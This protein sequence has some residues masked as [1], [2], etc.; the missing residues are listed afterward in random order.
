MNEGGQTVPPEFSR[1][2]RC[3]EIGRLEPALHVE[4]NREE[5]AALAQRFA[6]ASIERL[7]A[8]YGLA[9]EGEAV[10]AS[11]SIKA[12]LSQPCTATGEPVAEVIDTP[13]IIRFLPE[14]AATLAP[15]DEVELDAQECDTVF[16]T[17]GRIDIGEAVAET[18]ALAVNPF[19]R[20][21]DA[22]AFLRK[23]GVISEEEAIAQAS[24]FAALKSI[25]SPSPHADE[26]K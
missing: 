2:I 20:S 13:F 8:N 1:V 12:S 5:C 25:S 4:A 7:S 18:L 21:P 22:D 19:P 14:D 9:I 6:F 11:G 15:G 3:D 16:Y 10:I 24:P 23:M 17:D 26:K